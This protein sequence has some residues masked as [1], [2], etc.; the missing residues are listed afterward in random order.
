VLAPAVSAE[1]VALPLV[2]LGLAAIT[3]A[4]DEEAEAGTATPAQTSA[5]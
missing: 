3:P 2:L 4:E 1:A 5:R